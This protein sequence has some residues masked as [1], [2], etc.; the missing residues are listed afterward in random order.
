MLRSFDCPSAA[1]ATATA[2]FSPQSIWQGINAVLIPKFGTKVQTEA[3][4]NRRMLMGWATQ[5]FNRGRSLLNRRGSNYGYS[6]Q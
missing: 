1:A 5:A 2:V 6:Q 4:K 3:G